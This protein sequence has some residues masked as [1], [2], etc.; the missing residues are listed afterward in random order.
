VR[1]TLLFFL[2]LLVLVGGGCRREQDIHELL[3]QASQA[4]REGRYADAEALAR[5]IIE[6]DEFVGEAYLIAGEA[7]AE[8]R[9]FERAIQLFSDI[10]PAAAR[11]KA[12]GHCR[13]AR[14]AVKQLNQ[15][16]RGEQQF[17]LALQA[18]PDRIDAL[19]GLSYILSLSGQRWESADYFIG[20][21]RNNQFET[22]HLLGVAILEYLM[23]G[24]HQ[25][26]ELHRATP[27]DPLPMMGL[28]RLAIEDSK[29][30]EAQR[31]LTEVI[32]LDPS[33]LEAQ[34]WL[35]HLLLDES[36]V[37]GLR[38]WHEQLPEGADT[39]PEI[40][41]VHARWSQRVGDN[42][43]AVRC[44][45]EA[46]RR[47]ANHIKAA[48]TVPVLL[49]GLREHSLAAPF[50][51]RSLNLIRFHESA[52]RVRSD[53]NRLS[54]QEE[55]ARAAE[56]L[57]RH[58]E[59]YGW[60][61]QVL[62]RDPRNRSAREAYSR[63]KDQ[64]K[65]DTPQ[66]IAS[67]NPAL[68]FDVSQWPLPEWLGN[69]YNLADPAASQA[70]AVSEVRFEDLAQQVGIDFQYVNG[71][72]PE[73]EGTRIYEVDGGGVGIL[74]F[75]ADGW[76]DIYLTQGCRWPPDPEQDRYFDPLYRNL[77]NGRFVD[78]TMEAGLRE[79]GFGQG[80]AVGDYNNDGFPDVFVGNLG[81]NR[82][83]RNQG[84]GTFEDVTASAG[85]DAAVWTSSAAI[86]D[87]NGD[88][89]PD[90][91]E[92]NYL[93]DDERMFDRV[94]PDKT[95][96]I[97][98]C[99]PLSFDAEQ[100]RLYLGL[101]DGTFREC[102]EETGIHAG[103]GKGLGIVVADFDGSGKL[104][105]FIGNDVVENF[106]FYNQTPKRGGALKLINQA[107]LSGLAF[108]DEGHAQACMGIAAGD[109]NG[110]GRLELFVANFYREPNCLYLQQP[111]G[112]FLDD[113][114]AA[115]LRRDSFSMLG[116]GAQFLDG[117]SDGRFDLVVTNG[118]LTDER[119]LGVPYQMPPQYFHNRGNAQFAEVRSETLGSFFDQPQLGR[120]LALVDWNRDGRNDFAVTFLDRKAALV[121]NQTQ[122]VGHF[123]S[124]HLRGVT[125][126]RDAIG[127]R[128]MVKAGD[129][130]HRTQLV[131][132]DGY[133]V[134]CQRHLLLGLGASE[135]VERIEIIWP[136][137]Q[138]QVW[139]G[140]AAD[141]ELILLQGSADLVVIP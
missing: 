117:E 77:G 139:E 127:T 107:V 66:T 106:Y 92:V 83:Y 94:C 23:G 25:L 58:W 8:Q 125:C 96:K 76:P 135:L 133:Q 71:S 14:I 46:L 36:D 68:T 61:R 130:T 22:G 105:V 114:R 116:F 38:A 16:R 56:L 141:R 138:Q 123:V 132:G 9:D 44:Y 90:I 48:T 109:A 34:A 131:A 21:I 51:E 128:V 39:H 126:D 43:G 6:R 119:D 80:V 45:I 78:V 2:F 41:A 137:G 50:A 54:F 97:R 115:N 124:L 37:A 118:H 18:Q 89:V 98:I 11:H 72:D 24:R 93:R 55:T 15:L 64:L 19:D 136:D 79:N 17:R 49:N 129:V 67:A 35:G 134:A 101:G 121:T 91:Y 10:P 12:E 3:M 120:G 102:G 104:S 30:Q 57:G 65:P 20:L 26:E 33:L 60:Y 29:P 103:D 28:A 99:P 4:M 113:S 70:V 13:A 42:R 59:A 7:A 111:D 62:T 1:N 32:Q 74:D 82:L 87:L 95:G 84:D 63:L 47:D 27:D 52:A 110:D 31:L 75:D 5:Q 112:S 85:M 122:N 86:A 53:L 40:W 69:E 140:I 108:S 100:D 73:R 88:T 81:T